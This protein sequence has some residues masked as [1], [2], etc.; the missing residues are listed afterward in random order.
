MRIHG[1][2]G[3]AGGRTAWVTFLDAAMAKTALMLD[4][5]QVYDHVLKVAP[6]GGGGAAAAAGAAAP[7]PAA[8]VLPAAVAGAAGVMGIPGGPPVAVGGGQRFGGGGGPNR[9]HDPERI[10]RTI[11]VGGI[12]MEDPGVNEALIA[13]F[14]QS[15]GDV[16]A[17]R[18]SGRFAWV[19]F[20]QQGSAQ[21]ALTLDGQ[22]LG[23]GSL[24][25]SQSKTPIHTA[26]WRKDKG[27][28]AHQTSR[29]PPAPAHVTHVPH[30]GATARFA[31]AGAAFGVG[32]AAAYGG[33]GAQVQQIP[34]YGAPQQVQGGFPPQQPPAQ[35]APGGYAAAAV[36]GIQ[37]GYGYPLQP[38][39]GYPPPQGGFGYPPPQQGAG[40]PGGFGQPAGFGG[41]GPQGYGAQ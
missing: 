13:E 16:S 17:V 1:D 12:P 40:A 10:M 18:I 26:G 29:A 21:Q 36:S 32:Q 24:R 2:A 34:G 19:E 7:A 28:I 30:A 41:A 15:V 20:S 8:G 38:G 6:L 3:A 27:L 37:A 39:Y 5:M 23:A 35:M 4:G 11:H 22:Q 33:Y 25:I 14:F 9:S 31:P